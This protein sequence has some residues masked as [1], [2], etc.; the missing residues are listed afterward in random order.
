MG[1][2]ITGTAEGGRRHDEFRYPE[3]DPRGGEGTYFGDGAGLDRWL[4]DNGRT[5]NRDP[6]GA[7]RLPIP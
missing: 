6:R 5:R 3:V 7:L 2:R 1:T 4:L